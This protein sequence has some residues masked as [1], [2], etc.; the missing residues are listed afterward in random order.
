MQTTTRPDYDHL[1]DIIT[2]RMSIRRLKP[3]PIPDDYVRN[4]LEAGRSAALGATHSPGSSLS[5]KPSR[6]NAPYSRPTATPIPISVLG[7]SRCASG[8]CGTQPVKARV[9]TPKSNGSVR[10]SACPA[11]GLR[12]ACT[13]Q[14]GEYA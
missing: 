1:Y 8:R 14:E 3:E 6:S 4:I 11:R 7:W 13:D 2:K 5:S 10:E 12:R 9:I